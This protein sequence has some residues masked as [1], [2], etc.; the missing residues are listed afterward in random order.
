MNKKGSDIPAGAPARNGETVIMALHGGAFSRSSAHPGDFTANIP[1]GILQ[2]SKTV[3]RAF[4]PEY[5]LVKGPATTPTNPFPTQL[6]D[7]I[8]AYSY[9]VDHVG[10]APEN[11][12]I[13]G[14]S[15]GGALVLALVRYLIEEGKNNPALPR[16]PS[17]LV[18]TS[19]WCDIGIYGRHPDDSFYANVESDIIDPSCLDFALATLQ[20][21]GPL[22]PR[23]AETNRY[24]SPASESPL[25]EKFSFE[26]FPRTFIISGGGEAWRDQIR[27]LRN[28]IAKDIGQEQVEYFEAPDAFH[29]FLMLP[30]TEPERS[31]AL[32]RVAKWIDNV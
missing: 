28:K 27:L 16:P 23:A 26:G 32:T 22:G 31:E 12:I 9:L 18:L 19:P 24:I 7:A 25:M 20:Y 30:F 29:C 6:V 1:R 15:A 11:I 21:T 17:A 13:E 2:H 5:R 3:Q 8:A 10:F 4:T 14:D